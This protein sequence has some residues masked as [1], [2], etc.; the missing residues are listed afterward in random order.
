MQYYKGQ[1]DYAAFF[2]SAL[3]YLAFVRQEALP[4]E[5]RLVRQGGG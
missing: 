4:Q 2:R 5:M 3:L 1:Q